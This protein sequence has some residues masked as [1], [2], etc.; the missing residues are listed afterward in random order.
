MT[1]GA[2][3][4]GVVGVVGEIGATVVVGAAVVLSAAQTTWAMTASA[5]CPAGGFRP[6]PSR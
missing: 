5:S 1:T 4:V 2:S 6:R 3:V